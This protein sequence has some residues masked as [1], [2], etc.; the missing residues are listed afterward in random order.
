MWE[1]IAAAQYKVDGDDA[2]WDSEGSDEDTPEDKYIKVRQNICTPYTRTLSQ[3]A[4]KFK[5][6]R[7]WLYDCHD[8]ESAAT[9]LS[10][11]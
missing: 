3:Q 7:A 5:C 8:D 6:H 10:V 9:F 1:S 2:G 4:H 11:A